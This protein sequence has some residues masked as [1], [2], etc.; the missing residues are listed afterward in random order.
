MLLL[1]S[2]LG[3]PE[4]P[5]QGGTVTEGPP[6]GA[7]GGAPPPEGAPPPAGDPGEGG[8][9]APGSMEPP[10]FETEVAQTQE[11]L[12]AAGVTVSGTFVCDSAGPWQVY[13]MPPP[14]DGSAEATEDGPP[15]PL[16]RAQIDEAGDFSFKAPSGVDAVLMAFADG[17]GDLKPPADGSIFFAGSGDSL[18]LSADL[19]G[20]ELDCSNVITPPGGGTMAPPEPGT[21]PEG[22][23]P[24]DAPAA[25]PEGAPADGAPP[26]EGAPVEDPG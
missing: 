25:P 10:P 4:P 8:G 24:A 16:T 13:L 23:A 7:G 22:D 11:D 18:D 17:D 2:L 15:K 5:P 21:A 9:V 26:A 12:A 20:V 14:P 19:A 3:C 1:L 6:M